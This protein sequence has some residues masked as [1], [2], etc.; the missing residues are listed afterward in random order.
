MASPFPKKLVGGTKS[1]YETLRPETDH[2]DRQ[3]QHECGRER[4][5]NRIAK[6]RL[7][8]TNYGATDQTAGNGANATQDDHKEGLAKVVHAEVRLHRDH[9][10]HEHA[11]KRRKRCAGC[12]SDVV[13]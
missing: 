3:K 10:G 8:R 6:E 5:I 12:G 9:R 1:R 4:W 11:G 7:G 2:D 13:Y